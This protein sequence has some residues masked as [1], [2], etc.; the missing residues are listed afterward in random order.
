ML[1]KYTYFFLQASFTLQTQLFCL[2]EQSPSLQILRQQ[3]NKACHI[4]SK[5]RATQM[6]GKWRVGEQNDKPTFHSGL[7]HI[8]LLLS[9]SYVNA[10]KFNIKVEIL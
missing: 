9:K 7:D 1:P 10:I 5:W 2:S 4:N 6:N 8:T 3:E